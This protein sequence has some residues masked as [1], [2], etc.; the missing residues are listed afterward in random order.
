MKTT[1]NSTEPLPAWLEEWE[2]Y[3]D[4]QL[5]LEEELQSAAAEAPKAGLRLLPSVQPTKSAS[6]ATAVHAGEVRVLSP[7]PVS[8][9][10]DLRPVL[11]IRSAQNPGRWLCA[12]FSPLSEPAHD[13]EWL[14]P[15]GAADPRLAVL[16]LWD[17]AEIEESLLS[18]ARVAAKLD[19][20]ALTGEALAV[21]SAW[22]QGT[23]LPASLQNS[24]GP[25]VVRLI[26]ARRDYE[27]QLAGALEPWAEMRSYSLQK[28]TRP[29]TYSAAADDTLA[30]AASPS[31]PQALGHTYGLGESGLRLVI[32]LTSPLEAKLTVQDTSGQPSQGLE[33][34]SLIFADGSQLV[35]AGVEARVPLAR[36]GLG[37][38]VADAGGVL[39]NLK[40]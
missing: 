22:H 1:P 10:Q 35:F 27:A 3:Q 39:L 9:A 16:C 7:L 2:Q 37:F 28:A 8:G 24:I 4:E 6:T 30:L 25:R 21:W 36:L 12:P 14:T 19:A 34:G 11:V 26:D 38:A 17:S 13:G 33:G 18:R 15:L 20:A 32:Q 23:P 5:A 40:D 31:G 29:A